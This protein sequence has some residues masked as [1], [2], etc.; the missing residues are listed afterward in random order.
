MSLGWGDD[1]W[2]SGPW[3]GGTVYPTGNEANGSVGVVS[4]E[5]IIALSGVLASGNVGDVVETNNPTEDGNIAYG[6][7]GVVGITLTVVLSGVFGSGAVGTVT[8]GKEVALTG[9]VSSGAVGTVA[10]GETLLGLAGNVTTGF[11]DSV[12]PDLSSLLTG[13]EAVAAAG[14]VVQSS[15]IDLTGNEAYGY[16]GGVIVPLNSNQ[17]E[18]E[19]GS[20]SSERVIAL[21]GNVSTAAAGTVGVGARTLGITGNQ[22]QGSVG[23]LIAVY[24]KIIDDNQTANWQNI[25]NPQTPGW[26]LINDEQTPSWEEIEVTT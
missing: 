12:L 20:V 15:A 23:S 5:L 2:S 18:G 3:G 21:T 11:V 17:A 16:P 7:V 4:P 9:N 22:A 19:V 24:W 1:T 10:R 14:T 13:A 26:V 6:D 8:H 25:S